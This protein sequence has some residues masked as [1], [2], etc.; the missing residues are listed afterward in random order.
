[1]YEIGVIL[2]T[3]ILLVVLFFILRLLLGPLKFLTKILI[4]GGIALGCLLLINLIGRKWG[5]HLPVNPV[6]VIGVGALGIPGLILLIVL[7]Y[8]LS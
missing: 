7:T 6:S 4:N 8:L 2:S 3:F 1:M 5:V